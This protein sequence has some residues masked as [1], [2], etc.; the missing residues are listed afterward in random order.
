MAKEKI[1]PAQK[2]VP[3]GGGLT[4]G[5]HSTIT[6]PSSNTEGRYW[7]GKDPKGSIMGKK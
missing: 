5:G 3:G 6:T 4:D 1:T 2:A 7:G